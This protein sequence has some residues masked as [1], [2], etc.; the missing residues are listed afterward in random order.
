MLALGDRQAV[1]A[2]V[3]EACATGAR[4]E[5]ACGVLGINV[6]TLQRWTEDGGVKADGRLAAAQGRIPANKL[7]LEERQ[8]ILTTANSPEFADLPPSQIVPRLADQGEYLASES[9]FYRILR[10][11]GQLA[12]RNKAKPPSR[13]RPPTWVADDPNQLWSWDIS[14]P[15]QA[16]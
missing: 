13:R 5:A 1:M 3:R 15:Q 2:L 7:S 14:V 8:Y 16:A 6:R 10:E 4:M 9:S 12:H 11:V